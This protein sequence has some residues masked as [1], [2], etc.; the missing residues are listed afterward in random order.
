MQV[1]VPNE[2]Q[3][4]GKFNI[5][6]TAGIETTICDPSW[7]E[8]C[9]RMDLILASSNHA[10]QVFETTMYDKKDQNTNQVIGS[11]K[12][13]KPIEVLFEGIRLDKFNKNY[14]SKPNVEA[15]FSGIKEDFGFLFVGHWL[16]GDFSEDRKNVGGMIKS[17]Y[18]AFKGKINAPA[19]ILKTSGGTV[20]VVD[21]Y[22]VVNKINQIKASIDSKILP[23][24]YLV[25]GDL[26]DEEMNDLYNHPRVKAHVSFTR[27]EGFGRPLMEAAL[28]SKP[29]IAS[30]WSGQTDFLNAESSIL[31]DGALTKVHKSASWKGVINEDA[32]WFTIDYNKAIAYMKDVFKNYKLYTERSR[33]TYH[34]IKTNFSFEAM[35]EKVD[36]ILTNRLPDFPKNATLVLPKLKK[37]GQ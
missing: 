35:K 29:I 1:T 30:N 3:R 19:L 22:E 36:S 13:E 28:T 23:N 34:H 25:Y 21:R 24:V 9:N 10:K 5:G 20:S 31:I 17:F 11:L 18:E 6:V 32:E 15:V 37:I 26:T 7:I 2:F 33:K 8:G 16:P 27:G 14:T 4:I 12:L